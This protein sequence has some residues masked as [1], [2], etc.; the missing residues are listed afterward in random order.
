MQ[1]T[2]ILR[3]A[4]NNVIKH[5]GATHCSLSCDIADGDMQIVVRDNGNGIPMSRTAGSTADTA[6]PA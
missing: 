2:R 3:E 1:T 6:W 4:V 5:S